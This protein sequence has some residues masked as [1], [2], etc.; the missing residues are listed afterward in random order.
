VL[1]NRERKDGH[2]LIVEREVYVETDS[3]HKKID[4][5]FRERMTEFQ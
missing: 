2:I 4:L 3:N 1:E 5:R